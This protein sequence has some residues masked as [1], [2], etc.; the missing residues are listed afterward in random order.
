MTVVEEQIALQQQRA[1]V[2]RELQ[3]AEAELSC[4]NMM[5]HSAEQ[6][7]RRLDALQRKAKATQQMPR[8]KARLF[9]LGCLPQTP[10]SP[11]SPASPALT[12]ADLRVRA[13]P[14]LIRVARAAQRYCERSS[15]GSRIE[16]LEALEALDLRMPGWW[17]EGR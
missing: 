5:A 11:A 12:Q 17:R 9:E 10:A 14:E 1:E 8:I 13:I 3:G 16:C 2:L 15:R 4:L 6:R 7:R